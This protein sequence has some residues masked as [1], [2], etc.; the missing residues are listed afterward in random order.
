MPDE[1]ADGT[2]RLYGELIAARA[3]S[4]D[5]GELA[6]LIA[7]AADDADI[8]LDYSKQGEIHEEIVM[9]VEESAQDWAKETLQ[10]AFRGESA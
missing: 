2:A 4:V 9:L 1:S 7:D 3:V 10:D 8:D 5:N 6:Q